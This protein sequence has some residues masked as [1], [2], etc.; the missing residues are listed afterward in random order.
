MHVGA[1]DHGL[2]HL[3]KAILLVE[4]HVAWVLGVEVAWK[5]LRPGLPEHGL[6]ELATESAAL[7]CRINAERPQVPMR[8]WHRPCVRPLSD[9]GGAQDAPQAGQTEL[10]WWGRQ[11]DLRQATNRGGL[12]W[13]Q[14]AGHPFQIGCGVDG[15]IAQ[16]I[17]DYDAEQD[18]E[19]ATTPLGARQG[20]DHKWIMLKG[21]REQ[22]RACFGL[23]ALQ[24]FGLMWNWHWSHRRCSCSRPEHV[25][26]K[27]HLV[28]AYARGRCRRSEENGRSGGSVGKP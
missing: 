10:E 26:R 8:S 22:V 5:A 27:A 12:A 7:I 20:V 6:H 9:G 2:A 3:A 11:A 23:T 19:D 4:R 16:T 25:A 18:W 1:S 14:T 21:A 24:H 13:R 15:A 28:C 17:A